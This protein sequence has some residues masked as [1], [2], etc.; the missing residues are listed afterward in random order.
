MA[1]EDDRSQLLVDLGAATLRA[2]RPAEALEHFA[3]ASV[4]A[5]PGVL[6][7]AALGYEDAYLASATIRLSGADPS[8]E[9]LTRALDVQPSI[10]P[11]RASLAGALARASW[12][13]GDRD[14]AA[15]W[16]DRAEL[17]VRSDDVDGR[18]RTA[19]A[20]RVLAGTPGA[21]AQLADACTTLIDA[22]T[23]SGRHDVAV[24]ALRQRVLSLIELGELAEADDEIERFERL[25]HLKGEIQYLP[26][27]PLLR[28]MRM[29][30]SGDLQPARRLTQRAAELGE[31]IDSLHMAQLTLMQRFA[32]SRCRVRWPPHHPTP[33]PRRPDRQQHHLVRRSRPRRGRQRQPPGRP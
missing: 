6:A 1:S 13:S 14:A 29:L 19:F 28:A 21:A 10:S 26:Y 18:T 22:A 3:A 23:A 5:D 2:G 24:D 11:P 31:R 27:A 16:L 8:I 7:A 9:L 25:V 15:Q 32:L 33:S 12:Y 17:M 20:R 30:Q 4:G